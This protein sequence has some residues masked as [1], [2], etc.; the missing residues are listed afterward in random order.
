MGRVCETA[1]RWSQAGVRQRIA[2]NISSRELGQADFFMRLRHAIDAHRAPAIMLELEITESLAMEMKAR[3]LDQI[4]ALRRDGVRIANDDFG[5]G[6]SNPSR[7][8]DVPF[9]GGQRD[10]SVIH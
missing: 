10:T 1:A 5:T 2:I 9:N 7:R 3:T 4:R 6:H 8:R